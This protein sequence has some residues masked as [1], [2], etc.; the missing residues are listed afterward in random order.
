MVKSKV[1]LEQPGYVELLGRVSGGGQNEVPGYHL[2]LSD[3]GHWVLYYRFPKRKK[4]VICNTELASGDLD[5]AKGMGRWHELSLGFMGNKI[6]AFI[7]G[8]AVV[9]NLT[10]KHDAEAMARKAVPC[11]TGLATS[12][13][14]TAQFRD[15]EVTPTIHL[16]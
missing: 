12:R 4:H 11:F 15:F 6:S 2:C 3:A 1:L 10:D 8:H 5:G 9:K 7:D 13:W 16:Q 14:E